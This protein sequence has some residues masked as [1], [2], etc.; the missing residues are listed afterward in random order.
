MGDWAVLDA[1]P[2]IWTGSSPD[3][4]QHEHAATVKESFKNWEK[5]ERT[6]DQVAACK[7]L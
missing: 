2:N 7:D 4:V 6:A 3:P 5:A 1:A